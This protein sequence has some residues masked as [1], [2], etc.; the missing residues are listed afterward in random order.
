VVR[1]AT[2]IL[3]PINPASR[4]LVKSFP[5]GFDI[6]PAAYIGLDGIVDLSIADVSAEAKPIG[7]WK[8][9]CEILDMLAAGGCRIEINAHT[10]EK[11]FGAELPTGRSLMQDHVEWL[12]DFK[13]A[14]DRVDKLV[15][16]IGMSDVGFS[17]SDIELANERAW[18]CL[19]LIDDVGT[20]FEAKLATLSEV[21]E[22]LIGEPKTGA[23]A[24]VARLGNVELMFCAVA[25]MTLLRKQNGEAVLQSVTTEQGFVEIGGLAKLESFARTCAKEIGAEYII[26][27]GWD[28]GV[29][30]VSE[31][32]DQGAS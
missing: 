3:S 30:S 32:S 11:I 31:G 5:F 10:G 28:F 13:L 29:G 17:I 4:F 15:G 1:T 18:R 27:G 19:A 6:R 21:A 2:L 25:K 26:A 23:M 14:L 8:E 24:Q 12:E 16:R 9:L 20:T 7:W 22:D